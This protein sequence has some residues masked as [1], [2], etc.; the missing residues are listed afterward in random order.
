MTFA[1][2]LRIGARLGAA[3]GAAPALVTANGAD[4]SW[5]EF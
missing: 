4:D 1:G 3:F 5:T 2:N